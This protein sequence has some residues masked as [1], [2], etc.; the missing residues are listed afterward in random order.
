M[1]V[2]EQTLNKMKSE[3]MTSDENNINEINVYKMT[4]DKMN[5]DKMIW[6]L[7]CS[8]AEQ[9]RKNVLEKNLRDSHLMYMCVWSFSML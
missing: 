6:Y 9:W 5:V 2:N 1:V 7:F 3:E 8:K 4:V